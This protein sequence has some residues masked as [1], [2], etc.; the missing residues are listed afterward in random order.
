VAAALRDVLV[1]VV[2]NGTARRL[3]GALARADGSPVE[4]GGKTGTGDNRRKTFG[5]GARLLESRARSRTASFAFLLGDR[6]FG[7]I[8]AYVEGS[9]AERY[10]FTSSL[11]LQV[12]KHLEPALVALVEDRP[13]EA[14]IARH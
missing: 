3:R 8:T 11:P 7:V 1:E 12:L 2:E 10:E 9:A 5:T 4:V 14:R 13:V 6:H